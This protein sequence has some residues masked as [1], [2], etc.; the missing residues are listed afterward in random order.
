MVA[1]T[2]SACGPTSSYDSLRAV[3]PVT[4]SLRLGRTASSAAMLS[5]LVTMVSP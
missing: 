5:A 2:T 3:P 4:T 1:R